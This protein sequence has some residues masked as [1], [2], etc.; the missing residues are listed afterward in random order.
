ML[1][2]KEFILKNINVSFIVHFYLYT[3]FDKPNMFE[4]K[5]IKMYM[6]W[7]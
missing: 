1:N 7:F 2:F 5:Y 4:K 3:F 6:L